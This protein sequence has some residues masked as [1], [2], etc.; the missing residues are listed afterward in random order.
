MMKALLLAAILLLHGCWSHF[1]PLSSP[2]SSAPT[3]SAP[4]PQA[5]THLT[6][7]AS[8]GYGWSGVV[9]RLRRGTAICV[10]GPLGKWCGR[11]VGYGP[12]LW[13]HRIADLS[14]TVFVTI[15]GP[16]SRGLCKVVLSW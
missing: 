4:V 13:T 14:P 1:Q 16:L 11:S 9:T 6:G 8:W 2:D 15:C 12:A 3:S 5:S 7:I 10:T